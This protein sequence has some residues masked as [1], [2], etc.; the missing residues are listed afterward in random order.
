MKSGLNGYKIR[1]KVIYL[2]NKIR[3]NVS[4]MVVQYVEGTL[5]SSQDQTGITTKL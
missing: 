1:K 2:E 5:T 3:K 4:K